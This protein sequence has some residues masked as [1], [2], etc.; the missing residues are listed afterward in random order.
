M[1]AGLILTSYDPLL[2]VRRVDL[3]GKLPHYVGFLA[4]RWVLYPIM[5]EKSRKK[6]KNVRETAHS[7][8]T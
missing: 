2:G 3:G 5:S 1:P 6:E 8:M 7:N 4:N